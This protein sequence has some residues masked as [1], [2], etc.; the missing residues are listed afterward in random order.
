LKFSDFN[1]NSMLCAVAVSSSIK[2]T[3]MLGSPPRP[4]LRDRGYVRRT[5]AES[6]SARPRA[7]SN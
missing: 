6:S 4:L 5:H 7:D 1:I 3:R 2:S